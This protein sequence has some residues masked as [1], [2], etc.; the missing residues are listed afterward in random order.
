MANNITILNNSVQQAQHGG[1]TM[2]SKD[3][4]VLVTKIR[5]FR[6]NNHI[7]LLHLIIDFRYINE[8]IK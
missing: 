7:D 5:F 1:I 3:S 2:I 8:N 4:F 6:S